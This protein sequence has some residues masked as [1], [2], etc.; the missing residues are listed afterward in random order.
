MMLHS[1]PALTVPSLHEGS[2]QLATPAG[3][4]GNV[5]VHSEQAEHSP[6]GQPQI[7]GQVQTSVPNSHFLP[8]SLE[9]H[10]SSHLA[11]LPPS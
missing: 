8:T 7:L 9:L 1:A 10:Q 11:M 2:L 4:C 6:L 5:Q 3:M